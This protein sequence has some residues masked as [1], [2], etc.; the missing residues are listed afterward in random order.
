MLRPAVI[1][2]LLAVLVVPAAAARASAPS[3]VARDL[4]AGPYAGQPEEVAR[5]FLRDHATDLG[6]AVDTI[7]LAHRRSTPWRGREFVHLQQTDQGVPVLGADLVLGLDAAG[8]VTFATSSLRPHLNAAVVPSLSAE[9]AWE[10]AAGTVE[11]AVSGIHDPV[12]ALLPAGERLV[13]QVAVF[14]A[15]P[16]GAWMVTLDA[17]TG[18]TIEVRDLSRRAEGRAYP[19]NPVVSDVVDVTLTDLTGDL[20][21]MEGTYAVVRSAVF[22]DGGTYGE[23][24]LA[25]ADGEG[26]FWYDPDPY[27]NDDPF[28]EVHTYYHVTELSHHFMD[29]HDH[30]FDAPIAVT[31]NYRESDTGTY[32]NAFMTMDYQG[33][34]MLVFG[35]GY[36]DFAYDADV[37]AHEFGHGVI[38]DISSFGLDFI[39]FDEYGWN[40]T[41]DAIH[42]GFADYWAATYFGN[43]L[44]GEYYGGRDLDNTNRCPDD[45]V[46]ES[47]ADGMILGGAAWD[48]HELVGAEAADQVVYGMLGALSS[49]P[50]FAEVGELM[51]ALC[52]DLVDEGLVDA[53]DVTALEEA[54]DERGV[55]ACGRSLQLTADEVYEFDVMHIMG[56]TELPSDMCEMAREAGI[57]FPLTHQFA[58]T[59]PPAEEGVVEALDL[60]LPM[61]RFMGG[62]L[63]EDDLQFSLFV[64]K[65]ELVT[66]EYETVHTEYGFDMQTPSG[67]GYDLMFEDM[68]EAIHIPG[69]GEG[70][71]ALESDTTY[72]VAMFHMNCPAVTIAWLPEITV[73]PEG[74]DDDVADDDDSASTPE[75]DAD[76]GCSCDAAAVVHT[77]PAAVLM[78]G[79]AVLLRRRLGHHPPSTS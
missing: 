74:D 73:G 41:P 23:E 75:T 78:L 1:T 54:L 39:T 59:T 21:V 71:M 34:T 27:A 57:H 47:H 40:V 53:A 68:P 10:L 52:N 25:V 29:V 48:L 55:T 66:F 70:E 15:F 60:A 14:T 62:D 33:N 20:T 13:Y 24:H 12:L 58:V 43:S 65:G 32:D 64:R 5:A 28:A 77:S 42:E 22:D 35:Q 51:I 30:P 11:G 17:H 46:G 56:M 37:I 72:Y 4:Q 3:I 16:R 31:T 45:L 18:T 61:E 69:D 67:D 9:Q 36:V 49:S 6:L 19:E 2:A 38:W 7:P 26:D 44:V 8:V 76:D 63:S 79:L 50:S